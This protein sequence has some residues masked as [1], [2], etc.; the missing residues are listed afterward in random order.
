M[1]GEGRAGGGGG[2]GTFTYHNNQIL[3]DNYI[4]TVGSGGSG[5]NFNKSQATSNGRTTHITS[6]YNGNNSQFIK[7]DRT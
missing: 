6:G 7:V 3:N 4:I 2:A 5:V 1:V